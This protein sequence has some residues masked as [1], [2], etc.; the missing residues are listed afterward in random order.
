[1]DIFQALTTVTESIKAWATNKLTN[2]VDKVE[3]KILSSN[4]YTDEDVKKLN[5]IGDLSALNT[6]EKN[7][8]VG[9]INELKK[10]IP[11]MLSNL[12]DD[13][14]HRTVTDTEKEAWNA[15]SDFSGSYNDLT[16]KPIAD[17]FGV[18]VQGTEPVDAVD[19]DIWI[20]TASNISGEN[21]VLPTVTESDNGKV[22]VVVDGQ[23]KAIDLNLSADTDGILYM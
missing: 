17:D 7:T 12:T 5:S 23:W 4:D 22:L 21:Q 11:N 3:G 2:K 1:M 6:I 13:S 15:K 18:Y 16:N 19:G 20:D 14:M 8:L 10:N 9:S